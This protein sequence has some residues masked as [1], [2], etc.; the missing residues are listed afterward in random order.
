[1]SMQVF[2]S[3]S[4]AAARQSLTTSTSQRNAGPDSQQEPGVE[5]LGNTPDFI[6]TLHGQ[7]GIQFWYSIPLE[8]A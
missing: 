8:A 7:P 1:M 2:C 6:W 3:C 5:T 4:V